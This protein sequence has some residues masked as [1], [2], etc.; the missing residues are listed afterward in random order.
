[1]GESSVPMNSIDSATALS[2]PMR[3]FFPAF[4]QTSVSFSMESPRSR[5]VPDAAD[6]GDGVSGK[7]VGNLSILATARAFFPAGVGIDLAFGWP[8]PVPE[9]PMPQQSAVHPD[10]GLSPGRACLPGGLL[11]YE[12]FSPGGPRSRHSQSLRGPAHV[13][14]PTRPTRRSLFPPRPPGPGSS[15]TAS[16]AGHLTPGA[17]TL[18]MRLFTF[19]WVGGLQTAVAWLLLSR[20][21]SA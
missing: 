7:V 9:F 16:P 3:S 18:L 20:L 13:V 12:R 1:M 14:P 2:I 4:I 19:L 11:M 17:G 6:L 21:Y 8:E 15:S 10:P 5:D